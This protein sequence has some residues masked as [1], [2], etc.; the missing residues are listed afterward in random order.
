MTWKLAND[1]P[2]DSIIENGQNYWEESWRLEE[3]CCHSNSN[4]KPSANADVKNSKLIIIIM[5]IIIKYIDLARQLK[6]LWNMK[7][8]VIPVVVG[9]LCTVARDFV[10]RQKDLEIRGWM[11]TIQTTALLRSTRILRR[12][13]KTWGDL[14]SLKL[15]WKTIG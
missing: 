13:L 10:K 12:V 8:T 1:H 6:K 15:Q 9:A 2:N 11:E 3:T 5:I 14:L 4:E 7:I